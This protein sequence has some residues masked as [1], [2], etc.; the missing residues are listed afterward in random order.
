MANTVRHPR[1]AWML[2][3]LSTLTVLGCTGPAVSRRPGV[4][5]TGDGRDHLLISALLL[6]PRGSPGAAA[7]RIANPTGTVID[8]AGYSLT[9]EL[10]RRGKQIRA[11][12]ER[13]RKDLIF[14][15]GVPATRLEP[16]R[17]IWV[18]R[19]AVAFRWDF[20]FWPDFEVDTDSR[21]PANE[22]T[23]P[24]VIA[25]GPASRHGF[26]LS[27]PPRGAGAVALWGPDGAPRH[28]TVVDVVVF[29]MGGGR[30]ATADAPDQ[31]RLRDLERELGLPEEAL[32]H[33]P[34]LM[35]QTNLFVPSPPFSPNN[36]LLAR[37][38]DELGGLLPD[39]DGA[40]DWDAGA[41]STGL[42]QAAVH[43]LW[44]AGQSNFVSRRH[45]EEAEL[46]LVAAPESNGTA[47]VQAFRQAERS[48]KVHVYYFTQ[49]EIA[50]ELVAAVGRGV[51]VT[52]AME[53]S[54]VGT[55]HGFHDD[56]RHLAARIERAGRE[57]S[58]NPRHGLGQ[59]YWIR[60]DPQQG[61]DDRY[62]YDHSK[63][64]IIDDRW[65]VVGSENYGST[66]HPLHPSYGNRGW[67]I[68]LRTPAGRPPLGVVA[69]LLAVWKDDVDP[70]N[71]QDIV[72]Y[73]EDP[74]TLDAEGRGRYGPPPPGHEPR[75]GI[76]QGRYVPR[77]P[78]QEELRTLV[79]AQL[80]VS[81][82]TSL[83]ERRGPL[84]AI[85]AAQRSILVQHLSMVTQWGGK[86][87]GS[88]A[89]TPN[90]LLQALLEAAARGVQVRILLS[91]S[92]DSPCDR[93]DAAWEKSNLDND[94]VVEQVNRHARGQ[95]L[96][97]EA[98]LLDT[99]AEGWFEDS[100]DHGVAKIH[101]KGLIVDG[102]VTFISSING[103]ENSFKGNREVG[104]LVDSPEVARFYERLFWYDWTT[105]LAPERVEVVPG[106][107]AA[108][109]RALQQAAA[110]TGIVLRG[111]Q[112]S[113]PY[114]LRVSAFD[115][116]QGDHEHTLPPTPLGPHES[117]LSE[118]VVGVSS[119]SGTLAL[120]WPRNQS[121]CLEGDLGGYRI[122][123]GLRPSGLP[124]QLPAATAAR[125]GL[126]PGQ[127]AAQGPS[128]VVLD[129]GP[130]QPQCAA[131]VAA[132]QQREP[133][134]LPVC[135]ALL[136]RVE[137][138]R[139]QA[140]EFFPELGAA[141]DRAGP[142]GSAGSE[143]RKRDLIRSCSAPDDAVLPFWQ[144]ERE[145]CTAMTDCRS[146]L[147]CLQRIERDRYKGKLPGAA[148]RQGFRPGR[149]AA[150]RT[151]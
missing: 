150:P 92:P 11:R 37:D 31:R 3:L 103:V 120:R 39:T 128:P 48:I 36:R 126:Y 75:R 61:I 16:G 108:E 52:V 87:R 47:L 35:S 149:P 29:N 33:G 9:D 14:P 44:Y 55:K 147:Q 77:E 32:W 68:H 137:V 105:V 56:E 5:V 141:L 116:D 80:V 88:A 97:L 133:A 50:D 8:L 127:E 93:L 21:F 96:D 139:G 85:R 135:E 49:A 67:E 145:V 27:L 102:Q 62:T 113:T 98:R 84:A 40:A 79:G 76:R 111:L 72:R 86:T 43:R 134:A 25:Q 41:S 4:P 18:G 22:P 74:A 95:G 45:D 20:G 131:L 91:C 107:V 123:Y 63:Y 110:T 117:A 94:D 30:R 130:A 58:A 129:A 101:N 71:H 109:E 1:G 15:T 138:C 122:Y 65:I 54:L 6:S 13:G 23:I 114:A 78:L 81:P 89:T 24:D 2:A 143:R 90:L 125:L 118:E 51:D 132:Q 112:P 146:L 148:A 66:G 142:V 83:D 64:A 26:W 53:G 115:R 42:G 82:D 10:G 34:P 140:A 104:V 69:D 17:E 70:E 121:E 60:S 144:Q 7:I 59:V 19:D 12:G 119:A 124:G 38:R 46:T 100:E 28:Q 136:Q 106:V 73:S 151:P 57:R 99:N